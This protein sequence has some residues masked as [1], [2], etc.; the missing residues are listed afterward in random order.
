[1]FLMNTSP[2]VAL[3]RKWEP[4][5][6]SRNCRYPVCFSESEEDLARTA[7]NAKVQMIINNLQSE[8]VA[9][10]ASSKYGCI[11]QKKQK[12]AKDR[13]HKFRTNDQL[14]QEHINYTLRS[15]PTDLD[16]M[17]MEENA[18]FGPL[19]LN[20]DSDDSVDRDIEEAIQEYLRNK[21]QNLPPLSNNTKN[22]PSKGEDHPI[23]QK[24][25]SHDA[26]CHLFP[27]GCG[28]VSLA[29]PYVVPS[30]VEDNVVQWASSPCSVSSDDSFEQSIKAEIEQFLKKKKHQARRKI[31]GRNKPFHQKEQLQ[32]KLALSEKGSMN[33]GNQSSLKQGGKVYFSKRHP[34]LQSIGTATCL[35]SKTSEEAASCKTERQTGVSTSTVHDSSFLEESKNSRKRPILCNARREKRVE[36][37][38]L[39]DSSS[40]DG[41]EEAIQRYQVEKMKKAAESRAGCVSLQK[42]RFSTNKAENIPPSLTSALPEITQKAQRCKRKDAS[43]KAAAINRPGIPCNHL[44]KS[45]RFSPPEKSF[46]KCAVT[47]QASC[48]VDTAAELMCAEAILDISKTILPL[49]TASDHK[50]FSTS[51]SFSSQNVLPSQY[52]SD[53]NI[54]DSDDSIEQEIR[55]F[56]AVKARTKHLIA[57]STFQVPLSL[58][59]S[60]E[61]TQSSKRMFP[62]CLKLPLNH[63]KTLKRKSEIVPPHENAQL[64]SE[65]DYLDKNLPKSSVIQL[66][67]ERTGK[68]VIYPKGTQ[69]P[70]HSTRVPCPLSHTPH[71][72]GSLVESRGKLG[73]Q[74]YGADDKSSSFD[75]DEDLDT[76]IKDLLR[77][78]RKLKKKSKD[79]RIHCKKKDP[80]GDAEMHIFYKNERDNQSQTPTLLKKCLVRSRR[81]IREGNIKKGPLRKPK[82]IIEFEPECK[83]KYQTKLVSGAEI[84]QAPKTRSCLWAVTTL[85]DE[86][87]SIDSDDSIEEEIQ[88]FLAEK[89]KAATRIGGLPDA[90]GVAGTLG[91][92]KPQAALL[93]AEWQLFGRGSPA[94]EKEGQKVGRLDPPGSEVSSHRRCVGESEGNAS[95]PSEQA[96]PFT[97][98]GGSLALVE[99]PPAADTKELPVRRA[100]V[101][102]KDIWEDRI[103]QGTLSSGKGKAEEHCSKW[104]NYFKAVPSFKRKRSHELKTSSKFLAGLKGGGNKRKSEL[105]GKRQQ[106]INRSLLKKHG[107]TLAANLFG[108]GSLAK[109]IVGF[110]SEAGVREADQGPRV[111]AGSLHTWKQESD[112]S[113]QETTV[114]TE[115]VNL[116]KH[117]G[118]ESHKGDASQSLPL[119]GSGIEET[120]ISSGV[121]CI[122]VP[123]RSE[124]SL[125]YSPS[126][127]KGKVP[128][129]PCDLSLKGKVIS[130]GRTAEEQTQKV[131]EGGS[132]EVGQWGNNLLS[133]ENNSSS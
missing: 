13:G 103:D 102:R 106:D 99:N 71:D 129:G 52:E 30:H 87:S 22:L 116:V 46:A 70:I 48:R 17:D 67:N 28:P 55:A 33:R 40:D 74:K 131:L 62:K 8:E 79:Q 66:K 36:C 12:A 97:E 37:T 6:Q 59:Q 3:P 100:A 50:L 93:K 76:A 5:P 49:P 1:M 16:G 34:E 112:G 10:G 85:T 90:T 69:T 114:T 20:S 126:W 132:A 68:M 31:P 98:D 109:E 115:V 83:K 54:V 42:E 122:E 29:Q 60:S 77:S 11:V 26:A 51:P 19:T 41:I 86:S 121:S 133:P 101:Q 105:L 45:R 91:A 63:K 25:P 72:S 104:Q 65:M 43:A 23:Q 15:Y 38:D 58:G 113:S 80:F 18:E 108:E 27:V 4:F 7:V 9:L 124:K 89:A 95:H 53:N 24:F 118:V 119:Q 96:R 78:K 14:L 57:K 88:K 111:Q 39:S 107:G 64:I 35:K 82:S 120:T 75:S 73:L 127:A 2:L 92:D 84:Q 81:D 110:R 56:L 128:E 47:L 123:V 32:E 94:S 44:G 61:R 117:N 130:Q 125:E 21:G